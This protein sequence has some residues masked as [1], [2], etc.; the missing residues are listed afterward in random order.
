M[1]ESERQKE[2]EEIK[3]KIRQRYKGVDKEELD[4]LPALPTENLFESAATKRGHDQ[5]TSGLGT[6]GNLCG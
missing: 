1:A 4:L 3:I 2:K 6:G 5:G